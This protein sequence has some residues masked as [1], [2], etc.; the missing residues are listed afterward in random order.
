MTGKR[1]KKPTSCS[2]KKADRAES[3]VANPTH[4]T[5]AAKSPQVS[6]TV[7]FRGIRLGIE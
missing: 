7:C 1:H 4:L 6:G 2:S 5:S 3:H